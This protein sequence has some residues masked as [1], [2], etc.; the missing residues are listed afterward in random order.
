ML[1]YL[2]LFDFFHW[3][4]CSFR[5]SISLQIALLF[6]LILLNLYLW[7]YSF[8]LFYFW[9][10]WRFFM[11]VFWWNYFWMNVQRFLFCIM[12]A[13]LRFLHIFDFDLFERLL[14]FIFFIHHIFI[15]DFDCLRL[16][17]LFGWFSQYF[18]NWDKFH[19]VN[20]SLLVLLI[21][22]NIV[23]IIYWCLWFWF[24]HLA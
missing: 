6:Y 23:T 3:F 16:Q 14:L 13:K 17:I 7:M 24:S 10:I 20:L 2:I 21:S 4:T 18:I 9:L 11:V 19:R 1:D 15:I 8:E 12:I 22:L 5:R